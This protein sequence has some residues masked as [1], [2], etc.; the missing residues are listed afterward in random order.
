MRWTCSRTSDNVGVKEKRM[1]KRVT[2]PA[3]AEDAEEALFTRKELET[4]LSSAAL[5]GATDAQCHRLYRWACQ[6]RVANVILTEILKGE[7]LVNVTRNGSPVFV[8][9]RTEEQKGI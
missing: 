6:T 9:K 1:S 4:L 5:T 7:V 2:K 3:G 8:D